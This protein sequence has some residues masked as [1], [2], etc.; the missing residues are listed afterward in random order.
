MISENAC[1]M[2]S[3]HLRKFQLRLGANTFAPKLNS[4]SKIK[5]CDQ[6]PRVDNMNFA[7]R[8]FIPSS[9]RAISTALQPCIRRQHLPPQKMFTRGA[10]VVP[11]IFPIHKLPLLT[12]LRHQSVSPKSAEIEDTLPQ[13]KPR[14]KIIYTCGVY[15][16]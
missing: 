3:S 13:I 15:D 8:M 7:S 9:R 2:I 16:P 5:T 6:Q 4:Y 12:F 1:L 14:Y 11:G 10:T